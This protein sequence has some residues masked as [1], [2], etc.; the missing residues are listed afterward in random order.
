MLKLSNK[1]KL[2][3]MNKLSSYIKELLSFPKGLRHDVPSF[4]TNSRFELLGYAGAGYKSNMKEGKSSL[5]VNVQKINLYDCYA[6]NDISVNDNIEPIQY[7][8]YEIIFVSRLMFW[9]IVKSKQQ[10]YLF[11]IRDIRNVANILNPEDCI[12]GIMKDQRGWLMD[13]LGTLSV[14]KYNLEFKEEGLPI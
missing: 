9:Y 5:D 3:D 6:K 13:F 4:D 2:T 8:P 12:E 1:H 10:F 7:G 11:N 14:N